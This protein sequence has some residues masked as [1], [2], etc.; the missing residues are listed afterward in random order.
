MI[1]YLSVTI[2]SIAIVTEIIPIVIVS[3]IPVKESG[4]KI[5]PTCVQVLNVFHNGNNLLRVHLKF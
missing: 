5:E 3:V 4:K 2:A 1:F